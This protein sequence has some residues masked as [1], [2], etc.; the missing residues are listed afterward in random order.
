MRHR[1]AS[2]SYIKI[3]ESNETTISNYS[4]GNNSKSNGKLE[5]DIKRMIF[6]KKYETKN[7]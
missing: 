2:G 6:E 4:Y 7:P 1:G 3:Y 5:D